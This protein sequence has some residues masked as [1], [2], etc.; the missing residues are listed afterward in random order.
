MKHIQPYRT[1]S[2]FKIF[3]SS[4]S[5]LILVYSDRE[6]KDIFGSDT[7]E[8]FMLLVVTPSGISLTFYIEH[9]NRVDMKKVHSRRNS[10][11]VFIFMFKLK[12]WLGKLYSIQSNVFVES[13]TKVPTSGVKLVTLMQGLLASFVAIQILPKEYLQNQY[14]DDLHQTG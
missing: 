14:R 11:P 2:H 5:E 1:V 8:L 4:W 6:K 13:E 10:F 12:L 9:F 3:S 7:D